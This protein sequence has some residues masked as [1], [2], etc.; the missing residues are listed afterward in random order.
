MSLEVSLETSAYFYTFQSINCNYL[1]NE[2]KLNRCVPELNKTKNYKNDLNDLDTYTALAMKNYQSIE[3]VPFGVLKHFFKL[4][5]FNETKWRFSAYYLIDLF[6]R[7]SAN[8]V[9]EM[10]MNKST[11]ACFA[12]ALKGI[13]F[14]MK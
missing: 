8:H 3:D 7:F 14:K 6:D 12:Y 9:I 1:D 13:R 10:D 2:T 11:T 4:F 5:C